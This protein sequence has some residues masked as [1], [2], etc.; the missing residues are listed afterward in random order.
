MSVPFFD[1]STQFL[2]DFIEWYALNKLKHDLNKSWSQ[3]KALHI[4]LTRAVIKAR[5]TKSSH[6]LFVED[7][8]WAFPVDGLE[9]LL[10]EDKDVIG[11]MTMSRRYPYHALCMNRIDP[12]LPI[13]QKEVENMRPF[14]RVQDDQPMVMEC[15]LLSWAF[16]LVKTEVFDKIEDPFSY[17]GGVPNDSQFCQN[18]EEKGI[19][20]HV[21]F[22]YVVPHDEVTYDNRH[23]LRQVETVKRAY[24]KERAA[25]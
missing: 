7:D 13:T 5:K 18:C 2:P 10:A 6:I 16:T 23:L 20:R 4:A 3:R 11:F 17:W 19:K 14:E 1:P 24:Y 25:T 15:D 12:E 8:H 21:H 22:G 9:T